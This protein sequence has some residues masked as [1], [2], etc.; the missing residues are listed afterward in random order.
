MSV[1]RTNAV[2]RAQHRIAGDDSYP[3]L[4]ASPANA[5][6]VL[7]PYVPRPLQVLSVAVVLA[8]GTIDVAIKRIRAGTTTTIA[9]LSA[10]GGSSVRVL[11]ASS[12]DDTSLLDVGD[13]L[14]MVT[15]NNAVGVDLSAAVIVAGMGGS[16]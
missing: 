15:S 10:V 4:I 1:A 2:Q 3:I 16:G 8:S 12:L 9:G 13:Q 5:T 14:I 11:T 6:Y 7:D